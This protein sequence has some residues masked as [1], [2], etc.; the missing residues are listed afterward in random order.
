MN[1]AL[2]AQAPHFAAL[3]AKGH[4]DYTGVRAAKAAVL[5]A[6]FAGFEGAGDP[7]FERFVR[8]GGATLQRFGL[9]EAIAAAY[10]GTAWQDWPAE[11]RHPE[12]TDVKAFAQANAGAVWFAL[13]QQWVADRQFSAAASRA[14]AAGLELG[15]YRDLAVGTAPNGA[16]AW[17]DP[18]LL[19]RGVSVGA[20]PDPLGP[21]GQNWNLP[22]PDPFAMKRDG[23]DGFGELVAAN[24][25]HAGALRID[26]VMGL[27]RLFLIPDGASGAEGAYLAYPFEELAGQVALESVRARCFVVG[28]D[29]GTVPFGMREQL[30]EERM[31]S[32]RVLWFERAN[33]G[34][35]PPES[36]PAMAVACVSTHD[37]PTL[38]G[39][40]E[41]VDINERLALGFE[42]AAAANEAREQRQEEK[43][44]LIAALVEE[45]L[46]DAPEALDG[47][48]PQDVLVAVHRFVARTGSMLAL[49]QLDDLA[50]EQ[51]AVNLPG[52]DRERPNWRRRLASSVEEVLAS[53]AAESA[54]A[55][56]RTERPR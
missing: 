10:P 3:A 42:D 14:R 18:D 21:E 36:Y 35:A 9:F 24:M 25:R 4:V 34:F 19:M 11:L 1:A 22:P 20:P 8:E 23:Y 7:D 54:L 2:A 29:L 33:G 49:T 53:A 28:E 48:L 16:A 38:S 43:A 50:G 6:A 39:W 45:E 40:W 37:L 46:L 31:L 52:T 44:Q 41:G 47:A 26:H 56:M 55:A 5:E 17:V 32:Y 15:F 12:S 30:S 51:V 13:W 27:R